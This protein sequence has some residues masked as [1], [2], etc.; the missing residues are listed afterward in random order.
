MN[1]QNVFTKGTAVPIRVQLGEGGIIFHIFTDFSV[2]EILGV[3]SGYADFSNFKDFSNL[4]EFSGFNENLLIK[5]LKT[6]I[7]K[8]KIN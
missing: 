7:I 1:F 4:G 3:C 6:R 5:Q 2:F 8:H